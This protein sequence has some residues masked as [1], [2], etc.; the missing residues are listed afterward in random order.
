MA[1]RS[2]DVLRALLE[3][4]SSGDNSVPD[5]LAQLLLDLA[6]A[7]D[8][9][10]VDA[11]DAAPVGHLDSAAD[12]EEPD[13]GAFILD[14]GLLHDFHDE[15][16][17]HV[18]SAENALLTLE[19]KSDH[20][21]AVGEAFRAFHTLKSCANLVGQSAISE[22]AHL[23][24]TLLGEVRAQTRS[25]DSQCASLAL[26]AIDNISKLLANLPFDN[27]GVKADI[28]QG[29]AELISDLEQTANGQAPQAPQAPQASKPSVASSADGVPSRP[30]PPPTKIAIRLSPLNESPPPK[31]SNSPSPKPRKPRVSPNLN[32]RQRKALSAYEQTASID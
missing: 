27:P 2:V 22:L 12:S 9:P 23:V 4:V 26:R 16:E 19:K 17:F 3:A 32:Q 10:S 13:P 5:E 25:F 7:G 28:P 31:A 30:D 29:Y 6:T 8:E 18:A 1:L 24:E 11:T 20:S 21:E 15:A 14:P